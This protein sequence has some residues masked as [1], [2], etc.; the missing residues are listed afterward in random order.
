VVPAVPIGVD[1]GL[2][3]DVGLGVGD[4]LGATEGVGSGDDG[5]PL[6]F[7]VPD[8]DGDGEFVDQIGSGDRCEKSDKEGTV[9][10]PPP[11]QPAKANPP[12]HAAISKK[13]RVEATQV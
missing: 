9:P 13:G 4:A 2:G 3:V 12:A 8:G 10:D 11:P 6:P 1:D 5:S 7:G